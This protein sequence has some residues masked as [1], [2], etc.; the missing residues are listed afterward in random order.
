MGGSSAERKSAKDERQQYQNN[1]VDAVPKQDTIQKPK[2]DMEEPLPEP[3]PVKANFSKLL[4]QPFCP[5][6]DE[7]PIDIREFT[8]LPYESALKQADIDDASEVT[9]SE[10]EFHE[11][12]RNEHVKD[13]RL[14][15]CHTRIRECKYAMLE[16]NPRSEGSVFIDE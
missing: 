2:Y 11:D 4:D 14:E 8:Y 13:N 7:A 6:D 16:K 12:V 5:S 3:L 10:S 9:E 1:I 15:I